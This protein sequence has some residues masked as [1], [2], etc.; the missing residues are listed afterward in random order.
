MNP[1]EDPQAAVEPA[2]KKAKGVKG[3]KGARGANSMFGGGG[4]PVAAP[5]RARSARNADTKK[6]KEMKQE[7]V[8]STWQATLREIINIS[9]NRGGVIK[10]VVER[11]VEAAKAANT[12]DRII[13]LLN[14]SISSAVYVGNGC[15]NTKFLCLELLQKETNEHLLS[16]KDAKSLQKFKSN[17]LKTQKSQQAGVRS[18]TPDHAKGK[19][20]V[21]SLI[22]LL[23]E[24]II[25][26]G[27]EVLEVSH[28]GV[29]HKANLTQEGQISF[30]GTPF[31]NAGLFV[32]HVKQQR[33][34]SRKTHD[35]RAWDDVIY[36]SGEERFSLSHYAKKL[37]EMQEEK[38]E[39]KKPAYKGGRPSKKAKEQEQAGKG[40]KGGWKE[41]VGEVGEEQ[42]KEGKKRR[43]NSKK[44]LEVEADAQMGEIEVK[45]A[46]KKGRKAG[47]KAATVDL[48][49]FNKAVAN[50]NCVGQCDPAKGCGHAEAEDSTS[51]P[52][53]ESWVDCAKMPTADSTSKV[54]VGKTSTTLRPVW[55]EECFTDDLSDSESGSFRGDDD[56]E[57]RTDYSTSRLRTKRERRNTSCHH[58]K[59]KV[60]LATSKN[61]NPHTLVHCE[62]YGSSAAAMGGS[63]AA[64][65]VAQDGGG[66][67]PAPTHE[68]RSRVPRR[69]ANMP[70]SQPYA[71]VIHPEV[72]FMC[73]LHAHLTEVEI[74]GFLGGRWDHERQTVFVQAAFP[75]RATNDGGTDVEMPAESQ[76]VLSELI[77]SKNMQ[78]V[79][80]YHSHPAFQPDPSVTDIAAQDTFQSTFLE[81]L[82]AQQRQST[83][84]ISTN[85]LEPFIGMIVGTYDKEQPTCKSV[86]RYFHV[87]RETVQGASDPIALPMLLDTQ[88]RKLKYKAED[89]EA[90]IAAG[91]VAGPAADMDGSTVEPMEDAPPASDEQVTVVESATGVDG[92]TVM[93]AVPAALVAV[94]PA[95]ASVVAV[96]EVEAPAAPAAPAAPV[97][98]TPL[99]APVEG[100]L[101]T[102]AETGMGLDTAGM[103]LDTADPT[104]APA[105]V[106]TEAAVV[107]GVVQAH[108]QLLVAGPAVGAPSIAA[109]GVAA[110]VSAVAAIAVPSNVVCAEAGV[111]AAAAGAPPF[112]VGLFESQ[113]NVA[114]A[115]AGDNVA[116][117]EQGTMMEVEVEVQKVA[118]N[119]MG[120]ALGAGGV[121]GEEE[122][123]D[124]ACPANGVATATAGAEAAELSAQTA[125]RT[126][127]TAAPDPPQPAPAAPQPT[128]ATPA[129]GASAA[130]GA[131]NGQ[132]AAATPQDPSAIPTLDVVSA[133][134]EKS[135]YRDLI[136]ASIQSHGGR[137]TRTQIDDFVAERR[138]I[139]HLGSRISE[140]EGRSECWRQCAN[141][142]PELLDD[143][144]VL[145]ELVPKGEGTTVAKRTGFS[146]H[147]GSD[148]DF[149]G[150]RS[151]RKRRANEL[152]GVITEKATAFGIAVAKYM[153]CINDGAGAQAKQTALDG[154]Q[155]VVDQK[156]EQLQQDTTAGGAA[157][158]GGRRTTAVASAAGGAAGGAA[159]AVGGAE[160]EAEAEAGAGGVES[161]VVE[162]LE[163]FGQMLKKMQE[164]DAKIKSRN[165][166]I[167]RKAKNQ[168]AKRPLA[169]APKVAKDSRGCFVGAA[170]VVAPAVAAPAAVAAPV[171][172][173]VPAVDGTAA[174]ASL[175][176]KPGQSYSLTAGIVSSPV[177]AVE[178][179]AEAAPAST[180]AVAA[181]AEAAAPSGE[182]AAGLAAAE[183][184]VASVE[185]G[186]SAESAAPTAPAALAVEAQVAEVGTGA[187][188]P[189]VEATAEVAVADVTMESAVLVDAVAEVA[190]AEVSAEAME[191]AT[192][193]AATAEV[194][195]GGVAEVV[196]AEPTEEEIQA[197]RA[198]SVRFRGLLQRVKSLKA[199]ETEA[200]KRA[201]EAEKEAKRTAK[202][203]AQAVRV[204]QLP[205][206]E[207]AK[208]KL[209]SYGPCFTQLV[210]Q[211][212]E[213]TRHM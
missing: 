149:S 92:D 100:V 151:G 10:K 117:D 68:P 94:A 4:V 60:M 142:P 40:F 207:E 45:P 211:V 201:K 156:H 102:A 132:A 43:R 73:D 164:V 190:V 212:G 90:G 83:E 99:V 111:A 194:G 91:D 127:A 147:G 65:A 6:A 176:L 9:T 110:A 118:V 20:R 85:G 193:E 74:I 86:F 140:Y 114:A 157:L 53:S 161:I 57:N 171:A 46:S 116:W 8:D 208:A 54:V 179:A 148:Y 170:A 129:G 2:S 22:D 191:V 183:S 11:A 108:L 71:V 93:A 192:T 97:A 184:V 104:P 155:K 153:R 106:P 119:S 134:T 98:A 123:N 81:S 72:P 166:H 47:R 87:R 180:P 187:S 154:L 1:P 178:P 173:A 182:A 141:P 95:A 38:E 210:A 50:C 205:P 15:S 174:S 105:V 49:V 39:E 135:T 160:A 131:V 168:K 55:A 18:G 115:G 62:G 7:L 67:F 51:S 169:V 48:S 61:P 13:A 21:L 163:T 195:T 186:A 96:A 79:G 177:S 158:L 197:E 144:G 64:A 89:I 32:A 199:E 14:Y 209:E 136:I 28:Q 204:Q 145:W 25:Q 56:D 188:A 82:P 58:E 113:A 3:A 17:Q 30:A 29:P 103:G 167:E 138:N 203:E 35:N 124:D 69:S 185:A 52:L 41:E 130:V 33:A 143:E 76:H 120:S 36:I 63:T 5:S 126:P 112:R 109:V 125:A 128:P 181:A 27:P 37:K 139:K 66:A 59:L 16:E 34:S 88:V 23:Q 206:A 101:G 189:T 165:S 84:K 107:A 172:V 196:V 175:F 202:R 80:W 121:H 24:G 31:E 159:A 77:Q 133:I 122:R 150:E 70:M 75:S 26:P 162:S 137:A 78:V 12:G 19:D 200:I 152:D 42:A 198:V 213:R 146:S 44:K